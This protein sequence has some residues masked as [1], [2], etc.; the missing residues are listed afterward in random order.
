MLAALPATMATLLLSYLFVIAG[1]QKLSTFNYFQ[2]VLA[3]Y[4]ILPKSWVPLVARTLPLLEVGAGLALLVPFAHDPALMLLTV[5]LAIYSAAI[6][7][8]ILRGRSEIDCGCA[9]PGQEQAISAWLIVRNT[10]LLSLALLARTMPQAETI[11]AMGWVVGLLGAV[12]AAVIYHSSNQLIAN[13]NLL[14]RI[15]QHG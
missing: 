15:A 6:A 8:N 10:V 13:R 9:G 11:G 1:W 3:D 5:L 14:R 2:Q 7:L 12:L 4:Q